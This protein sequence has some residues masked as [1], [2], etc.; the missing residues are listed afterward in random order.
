MTMTGWE[1]SLNALLFGF[2]AGCAPYYPKEAPEAGPYGLVVVDWPGYIH[3]ID[4]YAIK[5]SSH[6]FRVVRLLPGQTTLD[7]GFASGDFGSKIN[8]ISFVVKEGIRHTIGIEVDD[9]SG[10]KPLKRFLGSY[11]TFKDQMPWRGYL[12]LTEPIKDYWTSHPAK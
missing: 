4:G 3:A 1:K 7:L 8:K 6:W 9:G 5:G 12:K 2:V 10:F 11:Y